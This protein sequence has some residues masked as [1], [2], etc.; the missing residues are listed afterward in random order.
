MT[1]IIP[2]QSKLNEIQQNLKCKKTLYNKF[3]KYY[4]R[5]AE[6]ILESVKPL[7]GEATLTIS[8]KIICVG[9]RNYI[10]A[11]VTLKF[12]DEEWTSTASARE[13]LAK[14]G[15]DE[16]QVTGAASSYARKYALNGLFM[17]DDNQD[18]DTTDNSG[19]DM[20]K[21]K[22]EVAKC[23]T[24]AALKKLYQANSSAGEEFGKIV[25]AKKLSLQ[26]K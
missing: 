7:L 5:S 4:Y 19:V 24:L 8:D 12:N 1:K 13:A 20:K 16:A 18:P 23:K 21:L 15:M 6:V 14:K 17:I 11:T 3:G 9:E 22:A 26:K 10:E 2:P 25:T